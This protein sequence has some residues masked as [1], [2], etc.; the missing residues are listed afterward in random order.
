MKCTI[1]GKQAP[2]GA[3]LCAPCRAA[4][5]RARQATVSRYLPLRRPTVEARSAAAPPRSAGVRPHDARPRSGGDPEAPRRSLRRRGH[6]VVAFVAL[7]VVVCAMGLLA[8]RMLSESGVTPAAGPRTVPAAAAP[9]G[10]AA[11]SPTPAAAAAGSA[12]GDAAPAAGAPPAKATV[13]KL[14]AGVFPMQD[15][16]ERNRLAPT[17]VA[18]AIPDGFDIPTAAQ[19]APPEPALA[20]VPELP[21]GDRWAEVDA[22]LARCAGEGVIAGT[23]CELR[24]RSRSCDGYWGRVPQCPSGLTSEYGT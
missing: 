23:L 15:A 7:S 12:P 3:K 19:P 11:L 22:A 10:A 20:P 21:R 18:A 24:V 16:A 2:T 14:P 4:L 6:E 8:I 13:P 5:K 9:A 1:C 17:R